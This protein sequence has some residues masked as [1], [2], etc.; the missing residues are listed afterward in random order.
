MGLVNGFAW[1]NTYRKRQCRSMFWRVRAAV[2]KAVKKG[3]AKHQPTFKYDPSSY[4][5][6]FDDGD[7]NEAANRRAFQQMKIH[8]YFLSSVNSTLVYVLSVKA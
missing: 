5:L 7:G 6:N 4:A 2:K 3:G 1:V 8:D